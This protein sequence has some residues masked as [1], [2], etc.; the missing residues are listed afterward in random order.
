LTHPGRFR[1]L[2]SPFLGHSVKA[3]GDAAKEAGLALL[4]RAI[5]LAANAEHMA[6]MEQPNED[7][8]ADHGIAQD[9][10]QSP[11]PLLLVRMTLPGSYRAKIRVNRAVAPMR[12]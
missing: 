9:F 2:G 12:S 4:T 7:G 6:V 8:G 1:L 5:A 10:P 11:K 3:D